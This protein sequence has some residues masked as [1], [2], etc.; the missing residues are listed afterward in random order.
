MLIK[1]YFTRRCATVLKTVPSS[2]RQRKREQ[3]L[4][5]RRYWEHQ[6]RDGRDFERHCDYIHYNPVKHGYVRR[7]V[8]WQYSTFHRYV[9]LGVYPLDWGNEGIQA[10]SDIGME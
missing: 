4:W 1:S 8:D 10:A 2:S 7:P 5:Q 3:S 6:T 9:R